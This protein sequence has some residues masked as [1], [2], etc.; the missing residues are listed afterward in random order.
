MRAHACTAAPLTVA[1]RN[2]HRPRPA[3]AASSRRRKPDE[4]SILLSITLPLWSMRKLSSTVPVSFPRREADGCSGFSHEEASTTGGV[5][6]GAAGAGGGGGAMT[7]GAGG[8]GVGAAVMGGGGRIGVWVFTLGGGMERGL[9]IHFGRG[10]E[11]RRRRLE[12]RWRRR[13]LLRLRRLDLLDDLGL[14]GRRD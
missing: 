1:G 2:L 14:E 10:N 9:D 13:W 4:R 7:T 3:F 6:V 5:R 11:R 8:G 12:L